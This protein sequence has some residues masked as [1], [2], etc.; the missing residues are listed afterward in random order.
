VFSAEEAL[1]VGTPVRGALLGGVSLPF[2]GAGYR[3]HPDW[4]TR[5]RAYATPQVVAWLTRVFSK[6]GQEIPDTCFYVGDLSGR[7]G[8]G[9]SLHRSHESG[10]DVDIFYSAVDING[11]PLTSLPA[12]LRFSADGEI[13]RWSPSLSGQK[14][15][16][17]VPEGRF[18]ARRNWAVVR[19]LLSDSS[20]EVQWVFI[21]RPLA[22]LL[23]R[24]A[25]FEQE[26]PALVARAREILHQP[27][28]SR[29]H[30]DHMHVRV[31]CPPESRYVGCVDKG[32]RRWLKKRWKYLAESSSVSSSSSSPDSFGA[33]A[34]R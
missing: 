32:P 31:Y 20:I 23:L 29:P 2:E 8:G 1:S 7:S 4:Q 17:P 14:P 27:T 15:R 3:I 22:E 11:R 6:V 34:A 13:I 30:D 12:M 33:S 16:E 24:E 9:A 5:D 10:R 19:A 25:E 26:D 21:Y 28:D 18:D